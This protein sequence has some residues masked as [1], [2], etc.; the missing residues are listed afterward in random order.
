MP[1]SKAKHEPVKLDIK[2]EEG[3]DD[4]SSASPAADDD[5]DDDKLYGDEEFPHAFCQPL[6]GRGVMDMEDL[7]AL[8]S[9]DSCPQRACACV[10][11]PDV[12]RAVAAVLCHRVCRWLLCLIVLVATCLVVTALA[13]QSGYPQAV[14]CGLFF[15]GECFSCP[16]RGLDLSYSLPPPT[17]TGPGTATSRPSA[18]AVCGARFVSPQRARQLSTGLFLAVELSYADAASGAKE[19]VAH[20]ARQGAE[21]VV[22]L[23]SSQY[24]NDARL[25]ALLDD[26]PGLVSLVAEGLVRG[27]GRLLAG[28]ATWSLALTPADFPHA[29]DLADPPAPLSLA[30]FL[31]A[32]DEAQ[33]AGQTVG[34]PT[35]C[36]Y[37]AQYSSPGVECEPEGLVQNFRWRLAQPAFAGSQVELAC[38][39]RDPAR[40]PAPR[41]PLGAAALAAHRQ[42]AA[43]PT[44]EPT[45]ERETA[46]TPEPTHP[47]HTPTPEP[48]PELEAAPEPTHFASTNPAPTPKPT[49]GR[50]LLREA[51]RL[52]GF[53]SLPLAAANCMR[54]AEPPLAAWNETLHAASRFRTNTYSL[55]SKQHGFWLFQK[56]DSAEFA[57]FRRALAEDRPPLAYW[58]LRRELHR[59]PLVFDAWLAEGVAP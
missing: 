9:R 17:Y 34:P 41:A 57:P 3:D 37:K 10:C 8:K 32:E 28:T 4:D 26:F 20:L 27:P 53:L 50:R 7:L 16:V 38:A 21:H 23:D 52:P 35:V 25:C 54:C 14:S 59:R 19:Q 44:P 58:L 31:A 15:D 43:T 46:P 36:A 18:A 40:G 49:P 2:I 45:L 47:A 30:S 22:V 39:I 42:A 24:P 51:D 6:R 55:R 11:G 33:A 13:L 29:L 48:T 1:E 5:E 12:R 56:P